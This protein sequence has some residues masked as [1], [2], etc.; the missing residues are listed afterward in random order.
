MAAGLLSAEGLRALSRTR[1]GFA[2]AAASL[3]GALAF[4]APWVWNARSSQSAALGSWLDGQAGSQ[5]PLVPWLCFFFVGAAL[6]A[7]WGSR[8]WLRGARVA[9]GVMPVVGIVALASSA[10][11][12]GLFLSGVRLT[13]LY[14][15]H[16]FW[17]S[18]P[19]F[20]VFRTGL[21]L[22]WLGALSA[23]ASWIS[24]AF[25]ALPRCAAVMRALAKH[26][27]IAYV[28]H[29]VLLYGTPFNP[30]LAHG[31]ANLGFA[32]TAA[33]CVCVLTLTIASVWAWDRWQ[34]AGG[35][36]ALFNVSRAA[37]EPD[38]PRS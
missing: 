27:L 3:T 2:A 16:S 15:E 14:G 13:A 23:S 6:S 8:L 4:V 20:V 22:A 31:G 32:A 33:A 25:A 5:F 30:G 12:Y 35:L 18:N 37:R 24:G 17:Y 1:A 36:R 26:S 10:A 11:C 7:A 28:V 9:G 38:A 21:A 29:L 19:L 34:T